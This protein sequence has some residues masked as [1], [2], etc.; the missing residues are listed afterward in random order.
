[1]VIV[2]LEDC[3]WYQ[4]TCKGKE[5]LIQ[6]VYKSV[7][8]ALADTLTTLGTFWVKVPTPDVTGK[9]SIVY[10]MHTTLVP[11]A[12]MVAVGCLIGAAIQLALARDGAE[13]AHE[14]LMGIGKMI[15]VSFLFIPFAGLANTISDSLSIW[16]I[17][18]AKNAANVNFGTTILELTLFSK[19]NRFLVM[20]IS[21]IG[22]IA[23]L[24]QIGLMY[25]RSAMLIFICA[26][27]PI[28]GSTMTTR[29]GMNWWRKLFGWWMAFLLYK[30]MASIIYAVAIKA[31]G[32]KPLHDSIS[33]LG[34]LIMGLMLL[35]FATFSLP[36]LIT[37][38][39]PAVEGAAPL[40]SGGGGRK[41][42]GGGQQPTGAVQVNSAS[43]GPSGASGPSGPSGSNGSNG[44]SG[45]GSPSGAAGVAG[46]GGSGGASGSSGS[47]SAPSG[48]GPSGP[49]GSGGSGGAGPAPTN[50]VPSGG[51]AMPM[52]AGGAPMPGPAA[53]GGAGAASGGGAAAG[54]AA[55]APPVA[56]AVVATQGAKQVFQAPNRAINEVTK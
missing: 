5:S 21:F 51:G 30:P 46:S 43:S 47:N 52:P 1:M 9:G 26:I 7:T 20:V 10:W 22:I 6:G 4:W 28:I 13:K 55:A 23:N 29:T 17:D 11:V 42:S 16:I 48:G 27:V 18:Q 41:S 44:S 19:V 8:S 33:N 32:N 14:V 36:A 40:S 53:A 37:F 2:P 3:E 25:V 35:V 50:P 54:G 24:I 39:A 49:S 31:M 34:Q 56:A 38:L 45:G 12:A 15:A